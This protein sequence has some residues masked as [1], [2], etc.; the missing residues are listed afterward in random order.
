M[1]SSAPDFLV[2]VPILALLALSLIRFGK[3]PPRVVFALGVAGVLFAGFLTLRAAISDEWFWPNSEVD[4]RTRWLQKHLLRTEGW[5][6]QPVIILLG[7]S[8]T[9]YGVDAEALEAELARQGSPATVLSFCMPG[10]THHERLYMLEVFLRRLGP[11]N[12]EKLAAATVVFLSEVFDAY[13]RNPLYRLE[14]EAGT[15]RA[16]IFLNPRNAL[17]AWKAYSRALK[18]GQGDLSGIEAASLLIEH[19]ILNRFAVGAFS[20]MHWPDRSPRSTPPFFP[21]A[22]HK[23]GFEFEA[24]VAKMLKERSGAG[25]PERVP[26]PQWQVG[27]KHLRLLLEPY[28]DTYGYYCLPLLESPRAEYQEEFLRKLPPGVV[29]IPGPTET[30]MAALLKSSLWFDGVHPTGGGAHEVTVWMA[31][32]LHAELLGVSQSEKIESRP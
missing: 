19:A 29:K 26:F 16:I 31:E 3:R 6:G 12:R 24:A 9:Y 21:L 13:D 14:K 5:E 23:V 7:S 10:A 25:F 4:R 17:K 28:V 15:E 18:E 22:G 1:K 8:A 27:Q 11:R 30:K 2:I 32:R 20:Q